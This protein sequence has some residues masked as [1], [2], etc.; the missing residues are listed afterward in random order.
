MEVSV[1]SQESEESCICKVYPLIRSWNNDITEM[2]LKHHNPYVTVCY[3]S[4]FNFNI[5]KRNNNSFKDHQMII[6]QF[7]FYKFSS[8]CNVMCCRGGNLLDFTKQQKKTH[9]N[10]NPTIIYEQF[11]SF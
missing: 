3:F 8:F 9:L 1:P 6:V 7:Q 5:Y 10:D 11:C 2:L 4:V